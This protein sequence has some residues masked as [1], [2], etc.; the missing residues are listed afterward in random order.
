MVKKVI[1][2]LLALS[3]GGC[4]NVMSASSYCRIASPTLIDSKNDK[5]TNDTARKILEDNKKY[6]GICGDESE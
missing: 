2:L 3:M 5:L 6:V 1:I 4:A